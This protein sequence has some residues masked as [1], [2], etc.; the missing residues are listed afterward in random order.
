MALT[1][2][3]RVADPAALETALVIVPVVKGALPSALT[4]LDAATGGALTRCWAT[5]DFTGARDE[6]ALVYPAGKIGRVLLIGLGK[7]GDLT[8]SDLRRAAMIG[9]KRACVLGAPNAAFVLL[10]DIAAQVPRDHAG[11]VIAEGIPFGAWHYPDLKRPPETPKPAFER[12]EI[13]T[14]T[15]DAAFAA[16]VIRGNAIAAGQAYTRL[17]QVL[18]GNTAT[19]EYL[20]DRAKE[21]AQQHGFG[22]TV[23][24]KAAIIK[25]G[26]HALMAVAQ[27]SALEPR[28]IVLEYK[29]SGDAPVVLVGKG[30]TFDSGGISIKPAQSMEDMKYDMSGAAA[31]LG[32]FETL[33][34]LKPRAHV[35]GLIPSC[36]NMPSGT[37]F[38]PG[39]VVGSHLGKTIEV[40][41]TDAEGRLILADALSWA[42]RYSP[43]AVVDCATLTGAIVIGLGHTASGVM[44]TD[45]RVIADVIAAGERAGERAWELP[46]W[47]DYRDLIKSDI[48]DVKNSGGR[49]AGSIT[50]AWFLREFVE[51]Y[52]W[53]HV[54]IA[55][56]AYT[57]R[58]LPTQAKGPT[59][60][61]VR[62][63]TEF[64]L[65]RA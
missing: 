44:G 10:D 41:N 56:T 20:G 53:A 1:V 52:P 34:Q 49:P 9:G 12:C 62:L 25:E 23:L 24:D 22:V 46:L 8:A 19:P 18:P 5:G 7:A 2:T 50:A 51:G 13:V 16:G 59:G 33:G 42:R 60:V 39:D 37:A 26:M 21:L 32:T 54:D 63:F 38:K 58:E 65:A 45:A 57:E 61:M 6:T 31:V 11:Q 17:L 30:V 14:P 48:A 4:K 43:A 3:H 64:V 36:E 35:I 55:G 47:D 15:A 40:V 29:G 28:F 27:G